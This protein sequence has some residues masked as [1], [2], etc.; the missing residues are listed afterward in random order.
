MSGFNRF[1]KSAVIG[2]RLEKPAIVSEFDVA[3]IEKAAP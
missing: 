3:P 2:P 1:E